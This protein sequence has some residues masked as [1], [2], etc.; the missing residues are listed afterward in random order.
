MNERTERL[1]AAIG[2]ID[3][4]IIHEAEV[5]AMKK[6]KTK[7]QWVK[8]G[9]VFTAA[10]AGL[11]VCLVTAVILLNDGGSRDYVQPAGNI[12]LNAEKNASLADIATVMIA[13]TEEFYVYMDWQA[14]LHFTCKSS[15]DTY[16]TKIPMPREESGGQISVDYTDASGERRT[17]TPIPPGIAHNLTALDMR[18][19]IVIND[20]WH[21]INESQ[22]ISVT[23]NIVTQSA[24]FTTTHLF[25]YN[26]PQLGVPL[27]ISAELFDLIEY[28]LMK[29]VE[30]SAI[31]VPT[32]RIFN[33]NYTS[34]S[35]DVLLTGNTD[36]DPVVFS[37][38]FP[39][40]VGLGE[41]YALKPVSERQLADLEMVIG[42]VNISPTELLREYERLGISNPHGETVF[43]NVPLVYEL[44]GRQLLVYVDTG[45]IESSAGL[46]VD[47]I[48]LLGSF[49]VTAPDGAPYYFTPDGANSITFELR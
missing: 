34:T 28:E 40:I 9:A 41:F 46:S 35:Y 22:S 19:N 12:S 38:M 29:L 42:L 24:K 17:F 27:V 39:G 11:A 23:R 16:S 43:V 8:L 32:I 37:G 49:G 20:V 5:L 14:G 15:G 25:G 18:G 48:N 33:N 10:A 47:K 6:I 44:E 21:N 3:E 13:E 31:D 26:L 45:N 4:R 1:F 36:F 2:G 7:R 30:L